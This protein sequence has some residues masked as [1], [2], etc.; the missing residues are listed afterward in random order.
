MKTR[1]LTLLALALAL[2]VTAA[3]A[4]PVIVPTGDAKKLADR[5]ALTK[6][7][8]DALLG[9]RMHPKAFPATVVPNPFYKT[10][11][12][13]E[14]P[15]QP[16]TVTEQAPQPDAPDLS[17]ND[18][19][20]K[21]ATALKLSGYLIRDGEPHFTANGAVCKVGDVITVGS[22]DR[23]VFLHVMSLTPQEVTLRY[24]EAT[25]VL[26]LRK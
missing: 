14:A 3:F 5:Y 25:Y 12:G 15:P 19:L 22:K 18:T 8:I 4:A 2:P 7:R 13:G 9:A 11:A 10:L 23:P 16:E 26:P 6:A 24:N 17:D 1:S 21:Y 20:A